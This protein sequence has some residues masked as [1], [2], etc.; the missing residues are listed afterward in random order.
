MQAETEEPERRSSILRRVVVIAAWLLAAVGAVLFAGALWVRRTFGK[1]SV[2]QML[3][4]LPGAGGEGVTAAEGD[5]ISGFVWQV[6]IVPLGALLLL[7]AAIWFARRLSTRHASSSNR[8]TPSR[9]GMFGRATLALLAIGAFVAGAA[10]FAQTIGLSQYLRTMQ[11]SLSMDDYYAAPPLNE[12]EAVATLH[13]DG[14]TRQNL[15]IIYLES[16]EDA[17]GEQ[18]TFGADLLAPVKTATA[19]WASIPNLREY[20]GGG[21]TMAGLVGT[22][23]G[24]PLR[25]PG[26]G[27]NDIRSNE[28]GAD[29]E[30]YLPAATCLGDVLAADGY[31]NVFLGGADAAF[32]SKADFLRSHGYDEVKDLDYWIEAGETEISGWGLSDRALMEQAKAEVTRLHESAQPFSL[33]MLTLDSHE[34]AHLF[35]YCQETP[36]DPLSDAIRCS[37][38]QVAGFLR[39]MHE[40]GYLDDTTVVLMGDHPKMVAE[41]GHF[42]DELASREA[43]PIFNR[44]WVPDSD[45]AF[46]AETDQLSMFATMLQLLGFETEDRRAGLGVSALVGSPWEALGFTPERYEELITSRSEPLYQR[47]WGVQVEGSVEAID[48]G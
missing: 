9:L 46:V 32:A 18:A 14:A 29:A 17:F 43:R 8:S 27:V 35:D 23:C 19:G 44:V 39:Y 31:E 30:G 3:M 12:A 36:E 1:I 7:G 45:L 4:H 47:L 11:T 6:L 34:P 28:I 20:E 15:V 40:A 42:W 24:L 41:G 5:Y 33:T 2:D 37:M 38:E 10:V 26:I 22:Q 48:A 13:S 25:G 21:W 16:I